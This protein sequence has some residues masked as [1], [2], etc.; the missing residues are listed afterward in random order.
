M[1]TWLRQTKQSCCATACLVSLLGPA[2]AEGQVVRGRLLD[3]L[4]GSSIGTAMI[5]LVNPQELEE[6]RVL[7]RSNSGL[8][9]LEAPRPG[10][11]RLRA[12]RIGYATSYS[13]FFDLAAGD[14][15]VIE[16]RADVEAISLRG[17]EA[18]ADR[19]CRVRPGEGLAVTRVWEE[20]RKAL[21]AAAWT[22]ELGLYRYDVLRIKRR[23]D[24]RV[25]TVLTEDRIYSELLAAAP[26]VSRPADSL[27][28]EGF[29]RYSPDESFFWAPDAEVLLSDAFLDTHCLLIRGGRSNEAGVVGLDFE[30]LP[31][32]NVPEIA[33]TM[34]L[35]EATSR[36][37]RLEFEY[38]NI[39]AP[40]SLMDAEPGGRVEFQ[41]LPDGTWIVTSWSLRLFRARV[42]P[43]GF[44]N[45]SRVELDGITLE[46]GEVL[47]AQDNNGTVFQGNPG[48]RIAGTV[49]D[50]TGAGLPGARVFV[51][52][53]GT[54]VLTDSRGR[55]E[56]TH[57]GTGTYTVQWEHPYLTQVAYQPEWAEVRMGQDIDELELIEFEAPSLEEVI[58]D[59]CDG[60]AQ[61]AAPM[62]S[63]VDWVARSVILTGRLTGQ[64]PKPAEE[65]SVRVYST[66]FEAGSFFESLDLDQLAGRTWQI[67]AEA[68]VSANGFYG[69]CWLPAGSRLIVAAVAADDDL[70]ANDVGQVL[71]LVELFPGSVRFINIPPDAP[72][73]ILDLRIGTR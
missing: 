27:R 19:Q 33:G 57:L 40:E 15:L 42:D 65:M 7:S 55:F 9:Q 56:L 37:R 3:A 20:A 18:V 31:N 22:Q 35:D 73:R 71:R 63:G 23:L 47:R 69:A 39:N 5:V 36:L 21:E 52:G 66:A 60:V 4:D 24:R 16:I 32:R 11:F 58:N 51:S 29:A 10:N 64:T 17:I 13:D 43:E 48:R 38:L 67:L 1:L 28:A 41:A 68:P 12:E 53:E 14:T 25:H 62:L 34:W 6:A 46:Q 70:D 8:F 45:R 61:P 54:E 44:G 30:P 2:L 72:F 50:S 59:I 26:Y 49:F